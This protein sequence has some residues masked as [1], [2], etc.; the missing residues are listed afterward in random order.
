MVTNHTAGFVLCFQVTNNIKCVHKYLVIVASHGFPMNKYRSCLRILSDPRGEEIWCTSVCKKEMFETIPL[1]PWRCYTLKSGDVS[2]FKLGSQILADYRVTD[3]R[4][5][6]VM[7]G[8]SFKIS[9][10]HMSS[11]KNERKATSTI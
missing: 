10:H 1:F 5:I 11:T 7:P 4:L 9:H 8:N 2:V 3:E 6:P